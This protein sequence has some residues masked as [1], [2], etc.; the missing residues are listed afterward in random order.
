[1][2]KE[3][4]VL[5]ILLLPQ[6][7]YLRGKIS[8]NLNQPNKPSSVPVSCQNR[9]LIFILTAGM[10]LVPSMIWGMLWKQ[11]FSYVLWDPIKHGQ[12]VDELLSAVLSPSEI[13]VIKIAAH[14]QRTE[15]ECQGNNPGWL[16]CEGSTSGVRKSYNPREWRPFYFYMRIFCRQTCHPDVLA[17]WRQSSESEKVRWVNSDCKFNKQSYGKIKTAVCFFSALWPI[18]VFS[19]CILLP[20][21][22]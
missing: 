16:S 13:A 18:P 14:T 7:N 15:P 5:V 10:L 17:K 22:T 20:C 11:R 3:I 12:Q 2:R 1:M 8:H 21:H 6:M 19:F 4:S 9:L